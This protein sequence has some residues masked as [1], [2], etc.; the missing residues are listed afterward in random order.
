MIDNP[1]SPDVGIPEFV[2]LIAEE[3]RKAVE[4]RVKRRSDRPHIEIRSVCVRVDVRQTLD[5]L[6]NAPQT[7]SCNVIAILWRNEVC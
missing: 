4:V 6:P 2:A 5:R 7:P 3:I 1:R